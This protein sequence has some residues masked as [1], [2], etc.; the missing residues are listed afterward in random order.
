MRMVLAVVVIACVVFYFFTSMNNQKAAKENIAV[1]NSFLAENKLKDGVTTTA[2]GLQYQVLEAGTG[3]E[4]PKASDT[5]T[6]HYHGTLIDGTVFDSSVERGEPIAFP[7]NRV[8]KGWTE[9]VQLMVVGEK[10]RFF[11]P[12]ELAYGNRSAGKIAAGSTLIFDVELIS[13]D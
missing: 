5:V 8:I 10:A 2:S 9:G 13:I 1:G 12:S 3:T 7:L 4:H 11:I 6:V